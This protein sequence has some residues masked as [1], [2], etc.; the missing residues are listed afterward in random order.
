[1]SE[2]IVM[3]A[4]KSLLKYIETARNMEKDGLKFYKKALKTADD[5]NSRGL[6]KLLVAEEVQHL[7]YFTK[8]GKKFDPGKASLKQLK[9]PLFNKN[10]YK[11]IKGRRTPT[12]DIFNTALEMEQKGIM[13][14]TKLSRMVK[15]KELKKFLLK[16]AAMEKRHFKLIKQHQDSIYDAWMW[17][18][19]E[20]PALNT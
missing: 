6:L 10:A 19:L 8:L 20:M 5:P 15:E 13:Y 9:T 18:A 2:V 12:V 4:S 7:E 17:E 11:K 14:Y 3:K 16:I 1:M